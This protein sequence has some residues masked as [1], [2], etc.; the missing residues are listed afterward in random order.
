MIALIALL[1]LAMAVPT[2]LAQPPEREPNPNAPA[3]LLVDAVVP[4]QDPNADPRTLASLGCDFDVGVVIT[5]KIKTIELPDGGT[6]T[7][8]PAQ[9]VTVTNLESGEQATFNITGVTFSTP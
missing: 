7:T 1:A 6:I 2:V 5:G 4:A 3:E 9:N 8:A